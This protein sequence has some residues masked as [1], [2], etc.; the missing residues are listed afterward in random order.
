MFDLSDTIAAIC[1][2]NGT[3]AISAIRISGSDSWEIAQKKF[4]TKTIAPLCFTHM[5]ALHG[6]IKDHNKTIDEVI[7]LP[8]KSPKSY[9][10]EDVIEI[11]CHGSTKI[12][13]M[14]LDLCLLN[15]ARLAKAG[16]FTFRAF[17]NGKV[18]LTSAEAINEMIYANTDE[19]VY[20]SSE[21]LLGS[22]K[23]K[24]TNFR[25]TLF[26]L[27]T[28]IESSI[29]FPQDT[30]D[31]TSE[32]I[33]NKL[34]S[35]KDELDKLIK[36]AKEGQI[37]REGV[38]ISI[39]GAPNV[40]KSS[41][42]NQLLENERAI[43]A[44]K[45]GTT[46]DTIEEKTIID[47]WPIVLTD[48]AGI[49]EINNNEEVEKL[50]IDRSKHT[51]LNSDIVLLVV[52]LTSS[53]DENTKQ[54]MENLNSKPKIVVGNKVDL[55]SEQRTT[56][57]DKRINI[58]VSAKFGTNI[59][60]LKKL[61]LEKVKSVL[62]TMVDRQQAMIYVNQRQK[63]LLIQCNLHINE[64]INLLKINNPDDIIVDELKDAISKLDEVSGRKISDDIIQNI[65][66]TFCIGK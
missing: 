41:L 13:S 49:R 44:S 54:I 24:I 34:Q 47:G 53:F 31:F 42:L 62:H 33:V 40:G 21:K 66:A 50:G 43:V 15:G 9:T 63:E 46:T 8:F 16:E 17:I 19:A 51:L 60:K 52:D 32:D 65:F 64:A 5:Q 39:I 56:I 3:G 57:T 58:L 7:L 25:N 55:F 61:I 37:L 38:K 30:P 28:S 26:N 14:I 48:T 10:G 22:L 36:R 23:E 20:S 59:D 4:S 2:P 1:T 18:D 27:I 35:L 45:P 11:Y 12:A 6:Y 29:E